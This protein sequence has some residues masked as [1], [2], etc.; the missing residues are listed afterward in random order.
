MAPHPGPRNEHP[1]RQILGRAG[2]R[3]AEPASADSVLSL[4]ATAVDSKAPRPRR[5]AA[6]QQLAGEIARF[7]D[8]PRPRYQSRLAP[9]FELVETLS[10]AWDK[11]TDPELFQALTRALE[12]TH[13]RLHER[14]KPD[15][16]AEGRVFALAR[17]FS[18]AA[19]ANAQ[20]IVIHSL[21]RN[22][23]PGLDADA[24]P[25][26][27]SQSTQ[28]TPPQH[29]HAHRHSHDR[30]EGE[31]RMNRHRLNCVCR[32]LGCL[33]LAA[34]AGCTPAPPAP[35]VPPAVAPVRK[36]AVKRESLPSVKFVDITD[37]AGIAFVHYNGAQGEKLL[38]ETMGA[39]VAFFDYD[40]DGD[41]DLFFVNSSYWPKTP[42]HSGAHSCAVP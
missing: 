30:P 35:V 17:K 28:E 12:V 1:A 21:H 39:G 41:Q 23:A 16:T 6:A 27:Q 33:L 20:S 31:R 13:E 4:A 36:L 37:E 32:L 3:N 25:H 7:V 40:G 29:Q 34:L 10:P 19:N 18:P 8:G 22:G 5:L 15:E 11:E 26:W 24:V 14:L 9:L 42:G 2:I 38:P